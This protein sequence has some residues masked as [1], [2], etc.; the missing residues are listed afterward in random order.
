MPLVLGCGRVR[1]CKRGEFWGE[2]DAAGRRAVRAVWVGRSGSKPSM[3]LGL[4]SLFPAWFLIGA[5][6]DR[7]NCSSFLRENAGIS[8]STVSGL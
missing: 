4:L 5:D 2:R 3:A 1:G 6:D 8:F 7:R